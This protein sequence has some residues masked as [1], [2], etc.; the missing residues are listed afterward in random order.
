MQTTLN[1]SIDSDNKVSAKIYI[2][3]QFLPSSLLSSLEEGA[4]W[5]QPYAFVNQS[6]VIPQKQFV[7]ISS[8]Y[9]INCD[10]L[11]PGSILPSPT[12]CIEMWLNTASVYR[13][14]ETFEDVCV[15]SLPCFGT[16]DHPCFA[17]RN[18][19]KSQINHNTMQPYI[20]PH[21]RHAGDDLVLI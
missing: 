17:V 10:Q 11:T 9:S 16:T 20:L 3:R 21:P 2:L 13:K 15:H 14:I 12:A 5:N 4:L 6:D 18:C 19:N 8:Y 7:G 1:S